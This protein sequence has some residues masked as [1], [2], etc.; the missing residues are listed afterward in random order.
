MYHKYGYSTPQGKAEIRNFLIPTL[1]P[2]AK[3]LDVGAGEGTYYHLL[4][5]DYN[6]SAVEVWPD[7]AKYLAGFYNTVYEGNIVDFYYP[8]DYD[9]VIFGDVI[10]HLT[11]EDAQECIA[12]A[13]EHSKAIL[14]ALPYDMEQ[15]ALYG[16]EAE[17]HRQTK[18]TPKIFDERYPGFK[19]ILDYRVHAYYYWSKEA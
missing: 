3:I 7:T 2:G 10:E 8:Y 5:K 1:H 18:M 17:I 12:R 4:G 14:V 11:V 6:W 9:L 15:G 19:L 13:K 16:N